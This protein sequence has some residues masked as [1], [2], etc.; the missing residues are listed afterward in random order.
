MEKVVI[1]HAVV[2]EN[3][4]KENP[5]KIRKVRFQYFI[6]ETLKGGWGISKAKRH[7]Q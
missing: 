4:I 6:H 7:Y 3:F 2:N 1:P 5:D